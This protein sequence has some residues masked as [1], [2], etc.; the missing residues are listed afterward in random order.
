MSDLIDRQ[1]AIAYAISGRIRTLP[2]SEDGENWI[3]VEEVRESLLNMPSAQP[4]Q[5]NTSNT[6]N[7]LD[8]IY[9]QAAID[10]LGEG[11][12]MLSRVLDDT[13]VVG[14]EREKFEWGLGLIESYINDMIEL[15]SAQPTQSNASNVL[16][17]LDTIYRQA[18]IDE[19]MKRD[20]ALRNINWYDKPFAE[21]ECKGIDDALE[22]INALPSAQPEGIK[23]VELSEEDYEKIAEQLRKIPI[24]FT[25]SESEII[26]CKDCKH[27]F[28]HDNGEKIS[29]I[30]GLTR[31][32][33]TTPDN[34]YCADAERREE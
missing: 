17:A 21:G 2:T 7:A 22:I 24:T 25:L 28:L 8:T 6:L 15:P 4:T 27:S 9:R 1:A 12:E 13:D 16:N 5:T 32:C 34:W 19:L 26:R 33:G 29:R 18:A 14:N 23:Y 30:C 11:R 31:M 10:A 20:K 3:R